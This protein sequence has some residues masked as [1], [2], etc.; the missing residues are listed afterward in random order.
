MPARTGAGP[1]IGTKPLFSSA[2]PGRK[3]RIEACTAHGRPEGAL[4]A[5]HEP[6]RG[7][8]VAEPGVA[9]RLAK[10]ALCLVQRAEVPELEPQAEA[11]CQKTDG[12]AANV[13]SRQV[14]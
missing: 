1:R 10:R 12:A 4:E 3:A 6:G 7:S 13:E 8:H 2:P 5:E 11:L 14:R 9:E